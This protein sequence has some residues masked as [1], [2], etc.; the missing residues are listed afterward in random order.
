[1]RGMTPLLLLMALL[2]S[3]VYGRLAGTLRTHRDAIEGMTTTMS[4]MGYYLVMVFFA[5]LFTK[6]FADSNHR[7]RRSPSRAPTCFARSGF[8]APSPSSA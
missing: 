7:R 1:M 4:S 6:A 2:P 5:A 3:L 8:Q